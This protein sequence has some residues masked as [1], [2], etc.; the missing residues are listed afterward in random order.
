MHKYQWAGK[1]NRPTSEWDNSVCCTVVQNRPKVVDIFSSSHFYS[2]YVKF[3]LPS[4]R[5]LAVT[6]QYYS[7]RMERTGLS[8]WWWVKCFY[9]WDGIATRFCPLQVENCTCTLYSRNDTR[10]NDAHLQTLLSNMQKK[11]QNYTT[12]EEICSRLP[13]TMSGCDE[14]KISIMAHIWNTA[15]W[16]TSHAGN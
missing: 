11:S 12:C 2:R 16:T 7:V 1:K 14:Q 6:I 8:S 3:W 5:T 13:S 4:M 9:T 10:V 15:I